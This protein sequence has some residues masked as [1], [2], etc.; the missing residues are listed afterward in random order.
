MTGI[1]GP[2]SS[3]GLDPLGLDQFRLAARPR[4]VV[5]R[6]DTDKPATLN[7]DVGSTISEGDV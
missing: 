5:L 2:S 6:D 1:L 3:H 7:I 4:I